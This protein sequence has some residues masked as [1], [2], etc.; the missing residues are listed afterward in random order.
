M[1]KISCV[2]FRLFVAW[3][4]HTVV[5]LPIFWLFYVKDF[6]CEISLV[7]NL[8]YPYSC[9]S[10]QFL[11]I[12]CLRFH[13]WDFACLLLE[14]SIQL[15]FYPVSG[16]FMSKISCV[17]FRLFVAWNIHTVVF[18]PIFWLFY[19][20]DF[21][22][23]ISLVCNLKYPYSCFSS[24]FLVILCLRFH[25]WDFACLLLEISIQLI[26]YPVSGCFMSK[27]SCVRFRLFVAWNIHTVVFL[28]IFWLFYVKDFS[29]EISLVCSWKYPY[30]CFSSHFLVILCQRFLVWDFACL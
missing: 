7:C 22:C 23:E 14:I 1:S 18:L 2:R 28:P 13:V 21:S 30:S 15:I 8:K 17:R 6:S 26:F 19:V 10:S 9:F 3:N 5:F 29:C 4:I 25:V 12:L 27:I 11:V 16:C 20:K 24:Q